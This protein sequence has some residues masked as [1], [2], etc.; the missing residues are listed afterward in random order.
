VTNA[1]HRAHTVAFCDATLCAVCA[2][3]VVLSEWCCVV[4]AVAESR[5]R[6]IMCHFE[7]YLHPR[8]AAFSCRPLVLAVNTG[9]TGRVA[10]PFVPSDDLS[11]SASLSDVTEVSRNK[12]VSSLSRD[13]RDATR[14]QGDRLC[15]VQNNNVVDLTTAL[16]S[17]VVACR[18]WF[19]G[20][21]LQRP[22]SA[23]ERC[24][25]DYGCWVTG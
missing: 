17:R 6:P 12:G 9:K 15:C 21:T 20:V 11:S 23:A 18:E 13:R 8:R 2:L 3:C 24:L 19:C 22:N 1:A 14:G 16:C 4:T 25:T 10:T 5:K 7:R